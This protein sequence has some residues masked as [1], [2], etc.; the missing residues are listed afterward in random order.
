MSNSGKL[1]LNGARFNKDSEGKNRGLVVYN[2]TIIQGVLL[3]RS[4]GKGGGRG[5]GGRSG[6]RSGSGSVRSRVSSTIS[7]GRSAVSSLLNR[8]KSTSSSSSSVGGTKKKKG[9]FKKVGKYAV[10]G[11]AGT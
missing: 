11:L 1:Q 9:L 8:R 6:G 2:P 5:G 10:A 3:Y 4:P 7:R